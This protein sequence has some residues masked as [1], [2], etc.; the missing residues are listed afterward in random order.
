MSFELVPLLRALEDG[1]V[2]FVVS[3]GVAVS[4]PGPLRATEDLDI[5][6]AATTD[7]LLHLGDVLAA[8]D[9]R[10]AHDEA[11]AFGPE[12]RA[13]MAAGRALSLTTRLGDLDIVQ[14]LSGVPAFDDLEAA[15]DVVELDGLTV[16]FASREHLI[17]MKRAR[18]APQD[19]ADVA[20]LL[21]RVD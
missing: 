17:A 12:H 18:G 8:L 6:P 15:A 16:R 9:A 1:G 13:A 5:V 19:L 20:N 10:L 2:R 4:L 7:S 21:N 3:G 11:A 14:R